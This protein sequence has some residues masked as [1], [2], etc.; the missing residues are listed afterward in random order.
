MGLVLR[1]VEFVGEGSV[2]VA[3]GHPYPTVNSENRDSA[4]AILKIWLCRGAGGSSNP[5]PTDYETA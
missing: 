4:A 2:R 5:R 3:A 1:A